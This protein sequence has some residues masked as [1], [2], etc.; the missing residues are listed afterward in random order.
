[1]Q[2]P[3]TALTVETLKQRRRAGAV[4]VTH[5]G[6]YHNNL[7]KG[8]ANLHTHTPHISHQISSTSSP[9][10]SSRSVLEP[11]QFLS[12]SNKFP[13]QPPPILVLKSSYSFQVSLPLHNFKLALQIVLRSTNKSSKNMYTVLPGTCKHAS[14]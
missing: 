11:R 4:L 14:I 1:M 3:R 8:A 2:H 7:G 12:Q 13:A 10:N 5:V 9:P 6:Q